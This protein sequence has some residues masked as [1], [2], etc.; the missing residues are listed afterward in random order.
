[1]LFFNSKNNATVRESAQKSNWR[2]NYM[3]LVPCNKELKS[4]TRKVLKGVRIET[5]IK[6]H[7]ARR[8]IMFCMVFWGTWRDYFYNQLII[9]YGV[10]LIDCCRSDERGGIQIREKYV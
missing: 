5:E 9:V 7:M 10:W 4:V 2:K 6:Y 3:F 8:I 1:M